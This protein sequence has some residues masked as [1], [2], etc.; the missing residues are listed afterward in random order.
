MR[1]PTSIS[2]LGEAQFALN[3]GKETRMG[4]IAWL[5]VGAIAGWLAGLLVKGDEAWA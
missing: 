3:R 4:I 2:T 1:R 5:V